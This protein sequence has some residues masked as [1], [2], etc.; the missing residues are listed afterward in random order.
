MSFIVLLDNFFMCSFGENQDQN[1]N[2]FPYH[3]WHIATPFP[4]KENR[5]LET[6][7][8]QKLHLKFHVIFTVVLTHQNLHFHDINE[9]WMFPILFSSVLEAQLYETIF[10]FHTLIKSK[11]INAVMQLPKM[12]M[13]LNNFLMKRCPLKP[14]ASCFNYYTSYTSCW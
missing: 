12:W 5:K 14:V 10:K 4:Y 1:L 7:F 2:Q 13:Q 3:I 8:S 9:K 11:N 6:W